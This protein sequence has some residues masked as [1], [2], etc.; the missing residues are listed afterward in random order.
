MARTPNAADYGNWRIDRAKYGDRI[1]SA[2]DVA[3]AVW[4]T[5]GRGFFFEDA[6]TGDTFNTFAWTL[7]KHASATAWAI[8]AATSAVPGGGM[9]ASSPTLEQGVD[10]YG[11]P[12]LS[13]G[14]NGGMSTVWALDVVTNHRIE[15]GLTDPLTSYAGLAIIS[16]IDTPAIAN[17]AVT[18]ALMAV[19]YDQ[20]LKTV[21]MVCDGDATYATTKFPLLTPGGGTWQPTA[22]T[23]YETIVQLRTDSCRIGVLDAVT[24]QKLAEASASLVVANATALHPH[25]YFSAATASAKVPTLCR[26]QY[27]GDR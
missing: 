10:A 9:T 6:F 11:M 25:V 1:S 16:D 17:G 27:W 23:L 8:P 2:D 5:S 18:V 3:L 26:V 19:Q 20:T 24:G 13:G 21:Q 7:D 14:K 15:I 4:P 12:I 22:A